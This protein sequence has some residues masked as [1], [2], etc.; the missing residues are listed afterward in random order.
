MDFDL[1]ELPHNTTPDNFGVYPETKKAQLRCFMQSKLRF[2]F[3]PLETENRKTSLQDLISL[4]NLD[5]PN[6]REV[7]CQDFLISVYRG[8]GSGGRGKEAG[9]GEQSFSYL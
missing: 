8:Q 5:I 2:H 4:N 9:A 1:S 6:K 7:L 3:F